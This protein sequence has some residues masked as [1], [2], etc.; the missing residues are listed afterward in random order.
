MPNE[1]TPSERRIPK[2]QK[3]GRDPI[4]DNARLPDMAERIKPRRIGRRIIMMPEDPG[5]PSARSNIMKPVPR[6]RGRTPRP[7]TLGDQVEAPTPR[8]PVSE[9]RGYVR[10][11]MRMEGG[12]LTVRGAKFVEGPLQQDEPVSAGLTYEARIGRRRIA[13]GDVPS[14]TEWRSHPDP[15]GRPGME[16]HHVTEQDRH[17]FTV[18]I[19]AEEVDTESLPNLRVDLYDWRGEGPG[20]HIDIRDLRRQPKT[21]VERVATLDGVHPEELS[22]RLRRDLLQAVKQAESGD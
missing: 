15:E 7:Q 6:R 4:V 21:T 18:R 1:E 20:E 11:R 16:G 12:E 13:H 17:D 9:D 19:P 10:L 8:G 3:E 5:T 14:A 22:K 2:K